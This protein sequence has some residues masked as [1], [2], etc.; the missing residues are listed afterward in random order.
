MSKIER[1]TSELIFLFKKN[2]R[3]EN[4]THSAK[5]KKAG[6]IIKVH[7]NVH[8]WL[9]NVDYQCLHE[10]KKYLVMLNEVK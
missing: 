10:A 2:D 4:L 8:Y 3:K 9:D 6:I 7:K 5:L 1:E